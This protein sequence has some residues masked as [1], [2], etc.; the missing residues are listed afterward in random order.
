MS[1]KHQRVVLSAL[2]LTTMSLT[3]INPKQ[4]LQD[5]YKPYFYYF[6]IKNKKTLVCFYFN[7]KLLLLRLI[8]KRCLAYWSHKIAVD[9]I[10]ES[11]KNNLLLC[12]SSSL[13]GVIAN[14]GYTY[15]LSCATTDLHI[16]PIALVRSLL[17]GGKRLYKQ[18]I[19]Y[20]Y[21]TILELCTSP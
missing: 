9:V 21:L 3:I 20:T 19:F 13:S 14:Y 18:R 5:K 17:L 15:H 6:F 12:F 16:K 4:R 2:P 1:N 8:P 10:S 11:L 7:R